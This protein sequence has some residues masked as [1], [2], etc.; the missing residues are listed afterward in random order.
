[1]HKSET[2]LCFLTRPR[3]IFHLVHKR[4]ERRFGSNVS[5]EGGS[6]H[7]RGGNDSG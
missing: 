7:G 3:S 6:Y 2:A 5:F 4:L 1:M